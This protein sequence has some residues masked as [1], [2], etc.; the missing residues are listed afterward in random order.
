MKRFRAHMDFLKTAGYQTPTLG[1]LVSQPAKWK[2]HTAVIT[3]D[4]GYVDNY[5][6]CEE[7]IKRGMRAS[8]FIVSGSVGQKP[9]WP[10]DGRPT[11]RL[12]DA[13]E[14]REMHANDMEIGSHGIS[15][16][17]LPEVDD[18]ALM[19][20][21]FESKAALEDMLGT[22]VT[23]FAYPYGAWDERCSKAVKQAGYW[24]ACTTR[25]GWALRDNA[26]LLLRRLTVYNTD[27]ASHLARKLCFA[28]NDVPWKTLLG[29]YLNQSKRWMGIQQP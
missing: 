29:L 4:D 15:H 23:S 2:G 9:A 7:L 5:A 28:S 3:F 11:K 17:R 22:A 16:I 12:L 20:E 19:R 13:T 27:S 25:S 10:A 18:S 6:A 24:A 8:W 1:D 26:P 14:L 21:V